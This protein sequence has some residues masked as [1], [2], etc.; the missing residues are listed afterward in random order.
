MQVETNNDLELFYFNLE[1]LNLLVNEND[2]QLLEIMEEAGFKN[3]LTSLLKNTNKD[4]LKSV[5]VRLKYFM[6]NGNRKN[7]DFFVEKY[8][9]FLP[10]VGYLFNMNNKLID[11]NEIIDDN[12]FIDDNEIIDS[13]N[14]TNDNP[15]FYNYLSLCVEKN[16]DETNTVKSSEFYSHFTEWY[17]NNHGEDV[18]PKKELKNYLNEKLGKSVKSSWKGVVLK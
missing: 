2:P 7:L 6:K 3:E 4:Y 13:T 1:T 16:D 8:N 17:S 15:I 12:E 14:E 9:N 10:L 18:P 5:L 11:D